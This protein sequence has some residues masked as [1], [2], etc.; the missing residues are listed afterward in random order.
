MAELVTR[1]SIATGMAE[2]ARRPNIFRTYLAWSFAHSRDSH[3]VI[4]AINESGRLGE[5]FETVPA[6][7]AVK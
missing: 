7:A 3:N 6:D 4:Q 1:Y 5:V 2:I